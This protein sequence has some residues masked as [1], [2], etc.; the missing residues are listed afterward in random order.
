MTQAKYHL[1][2]G[3]CGGGRR[4]GKIAFY[5]C[6]VS[7]NEECTKSR[8]RCPTKLSL[9]SFLR[10]LLTRSSV[11]LPISSHAVQRRPLLHDAPHPSSDLTFRRGMRRRRHQRLSLVIFLKRTKPE[12]NK[13]KSRRQEEAGSTDNNLR[14]RVAKRQRF[15]GFQENVTRRSRRERERAE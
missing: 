14:I 12:K 8:S 6:L 15:R 11:R 7:H 5:V 1:R 13:K 3:V 2:R 4:R 9:A 10:T